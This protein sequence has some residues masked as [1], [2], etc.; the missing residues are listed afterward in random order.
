M[1]NIRSQM[2][3]YL[4]SVL[5]SLFSVRYTLKMGD[6]FTIGL[7]PPWESIRTSPIII[8]I[9]GQVKLL[10]KVPFLWAESP[11]PGRSKKA[12]SLDMSSSSATGR[13][14]FTNKNRES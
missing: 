6:L 12:A 4:F 9:P 8:T 7:C 14:E 2:S 11:A 10:R 1:S 5:C 3:D 13:K